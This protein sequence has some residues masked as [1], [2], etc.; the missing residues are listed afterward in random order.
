MERSA[1]LNMWAAH[2]E[3]CKGV[4]RAWHSHHSALGSIGNRLLLLHDRVGQR[5]RAIVRFHFH[6]RHC[7]GQNHHQQKRESVVSIS[8]SR[9][10]CCPL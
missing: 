2:G 1:F 4:E 10:A 6:R 9:R 5:E 3:V 7:C 8:A